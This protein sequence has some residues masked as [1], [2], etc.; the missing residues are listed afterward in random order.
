M[1]KHRRLVFE[2][3]ASRNRSTSIPITGHAGHSRTSFAVRFPRSTY[4]AHCRPRGLARARE[5]V[6]R[7]GEFAASRTTTKDCPASTNRTVTTT[8][9]HHAPQHRHRTAGPLAGTRQNHRG[10]NAERLRLH[11]HQTPHTT[12]HHQHCR[13][14]CKSHRIGTAHTAPPEIEAF[15]LF[16]QNKKTG[17]PASIRIDSC[18]KEEEPS[19]Q[20]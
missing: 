5:L 16:D 19:H 10:H 17:L 6:R 14:G 8:T 1:P 12:R 4:P 7:A 3:L 9:L 2:I 18:T 15:K 13:T 20:E 11:H